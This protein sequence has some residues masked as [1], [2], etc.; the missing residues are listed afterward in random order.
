[1]AIDAVHDLMFNIFAA[2]ATTG[3]QDMDFFVER[4]DRLTALQSFEMRQATAT[5]D[6]LEYSTS[7]PDK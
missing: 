1:M 6:R 4:N 7:A 5:V 3:I 2:S